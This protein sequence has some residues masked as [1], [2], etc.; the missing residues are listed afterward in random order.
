[1][2]APGPPGSGA[3]FFCAAGA[4]R[5]RQGATPACAFK[6]GRA[7]RP[8]ENYDDYPHSHRNYGAHRARL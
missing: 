1:M 3:T 4:A 8:Q 5:F 7:F 2:V 6:A